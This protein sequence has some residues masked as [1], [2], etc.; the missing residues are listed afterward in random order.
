MAEKNSFILYLEYADILQDTT[1][2]QFGRLMRHLF[3]HASGDEVTPESDVA[4]AYRFITNQMDRD[5]EKYDEKIEGRRRAGSVGGKKRAENAKNEQENLI[6]SDNS[7][8]I[9]ANQANATFAS[10]FQANSSKPKQIQANASKVKQSQANQADNDNETVN[11]NVNDNVSVT[12]TVNV[13]SAQDALPVEKSVE[14]S[15]SVERESFDFVFDGQSQENSESIPLYFTVKKYC[16]ENHPNVNAQDFY[17]YYK[18]QGWCCNGKPIKNWRS[19]L[20][21]WA[22]HQRDDGETAE[23]SYD[24]DEFVRLAMS[25]PFDERG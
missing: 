1:D 11:G 13:G 25:R 22:K 9:Q 21:S 17:D 8:Q 23:R 14:K 24:I 7:K 16:D 12:D 3:A 18:E 15:V 2:E 6:F 10:N 4:I 20:K 19:L 5:A